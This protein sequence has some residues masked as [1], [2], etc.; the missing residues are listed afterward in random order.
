MRKWRHAPRLRH[1]TRAAHISSSPRP[2]S[3]LSRQAWQTTR[4][5]FPDVERHAKDGGPVGVVPASLQCFVVDIDQ[6]GENGI[7]AVRGILGKP[8]AVI[9]TQRP[10]GFHA[11]YRAAAGEIGNRKWGLGDAGGDIR[12]SRGFVIL[13]DPA[14]LADG[15]AQHFDDAQ[16]ADPGRLPRPTTQ[17]R[18]GSEAVR[19]APIGTRNDTLNREAFKA[20]KRRRVLD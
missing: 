13:W 5:N 2:T 20:A 7:E 6:G 12:G 1:C 15:L 18:R 14:T 16:P 9:A 17:G 11:W 3:A 19:T 8:V 10:G 4:P